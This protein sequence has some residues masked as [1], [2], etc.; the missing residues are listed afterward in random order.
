MAQIL[1]NESD[2]IRRRMLQTRLERSGHIVCLLSGPEE[3]TN[4]LGQAAIDIMI[5]DMDEQSLD[6]LQ[7]QFCDLKGVKLVLQASHCDL[8]FDFRSWIADDIF[9]KGEHGENMMLAIKKVLHN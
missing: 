1:L 6:D 5:V 4:I 2:P 7:K 8:Q 3:I 9:C